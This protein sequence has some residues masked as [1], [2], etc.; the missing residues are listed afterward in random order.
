MIRAVP[1]I[2]LLGGALTK[3]FGDVE[4]HEVGVM[5]NRTRSILSKGL[6]GID[7]DARSYQLFDQ[8]HLPGRIIE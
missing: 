1:N 6:L 5:E 8:V 4:V 7:C 2:L 3:K